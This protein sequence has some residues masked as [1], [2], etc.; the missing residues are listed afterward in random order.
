M[1]GKGSGKRPYLADKTVEEI[2]HVASDILLSWLKNPGVDENKKALV[3]LQ[4]VQRR[5]PSADLN[6]GNQ[7]SDL[8]IIIIRPGES[9]ENHVERQPECLE[10]EA[11]SISRQIS[12]Q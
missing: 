1:G 8:R 10:A 4:L 6:S 3:A 11:T 7:L 2:V 12:L 9:L 5:I